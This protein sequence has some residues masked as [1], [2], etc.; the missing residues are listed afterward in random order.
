MHRL[1]RVIGPHADPSVIVTSWSDVI[2]SSS[3][4]TVSCSVFIVRRLTP[5]EAARSTSTLP[6]RST[7]FL[8]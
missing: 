6:A 5:G 1:R 4:N 3:G 7:T 2:R 8:P